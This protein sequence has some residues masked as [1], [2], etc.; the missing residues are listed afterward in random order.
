LTLTDDAAAMHTITRDDSELAATNPSRTTDRRSGRA[1]A[2]PLPPD[3]QP[4]VLS[5]MLGAHYRDVTDD[6]WSVDGSR[7]SGSGPASAFARG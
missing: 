1:I 7:C 6:M 5:E 3:E 4:D 2:V